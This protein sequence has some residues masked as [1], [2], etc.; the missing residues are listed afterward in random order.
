LINLHTTQKAIASQGNLRGEH[1]T[2]CMDAIH[3]NQ[4]R[5]QVLSGLAPASQTAGSLFRV[6][7]EQALGSSE[8]NTTFPAWLFL[9]SKATVMY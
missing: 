6:I 7:R 2:Q 1:A 3:P 8:E 5:L 4:G 9:L